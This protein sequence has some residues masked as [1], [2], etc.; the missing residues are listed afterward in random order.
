MSD[1]HPQQEHQYRNS[2]IHSRQKGEEL[3]KAQNAKNVPPAPDELWTEEEAVA[4]RKKEDQADTGTNRQEKI[5]EAVR[6]QYDN[7]GTGSIYNQ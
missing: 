4:Q 6:E 2:G 7:E 1:K 5:D 3:S